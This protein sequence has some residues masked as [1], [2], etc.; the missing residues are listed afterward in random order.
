MISIH[1]AILRMIPFLIAICR[2]AL[3][4]QANY[5]GARE[6]LTTLPDRRGYGIKQIM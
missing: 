3:P 5:S 6:S 1:T 2:L 4:A